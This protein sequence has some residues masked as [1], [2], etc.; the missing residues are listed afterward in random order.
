[1]S[2][3]F[4]NPN[5][6]AM[7]AVNRSQGGSV[8]KTDAE[9]HEFCRPFVFMNGSHEMPNYPAICRAVVAL[10]APASAQ[11]A[12]IQQLRRLAWT[13]Y[14]GLGGECNLPEPWLDAL[15]AAAY[16]EP[17]STE[18]LLPFI[19]QP[20]AAVQQGEVLTEAQLGAIAYKGFD[21]Y[22]TEASNGK[23]SEAWE[24][25]AKAVRDALASAQPKTGE[26]NV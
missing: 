6:I 10:A 19:Y 22:W 24:A 20:S 8:E 11:E 16:G 18:G 5:A 25:S 21:D 2:T 1:M 26:S 17:F 3:D 7:G 14:A 23:D 15:N 9:W 4:Q 13:C 12:E